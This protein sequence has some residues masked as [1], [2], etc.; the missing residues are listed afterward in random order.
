[1]G[2]IMEDLT[3]NEMEAA[4]RVT[5]TVVLPVGIVEQHGYHLPLKTD[6]ITADELSKRAALFMNAVVAPT[7]PYCYSGGELAGTINIS[8]L[9]FSLL[10]TD[11]CL[12][13]SRMGFLNVILFLGHGGHTNTEMVKESLQLMIKRNKDLENMSFSI[14]GAWEL[15][16]SWNE[17][18]NLLPEHD[19][20]AGWAETSLMMYLRPDLVRKEI[21]MDSPEVCKWSRMGKSENLVKEVKTVNHPYVLPRTVMKVEWKV[22][23]TGF[24]ERATYELGE[25][26]CNEVVEGLADFV[27]FVDRAN[28]GK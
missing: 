3:V 13:F 14:V 17:L 15:S 11:I 10:V 7:I 20:H 25:K 26:I 18:F 8:P 22:G 27:N 6:T 5:R 12:E 2:Y 28:P 21:V 16:A 4:L 19:I 23:V 9:V 24:P 1:M